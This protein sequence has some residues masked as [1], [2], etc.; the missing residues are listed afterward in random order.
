MQKKREMTDLC[1]TYFMTIPFG[2]NIII[3]LLSFLLGNNKLYRLDLGYFQLS[4]EISQKQYLS[5]Y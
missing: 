3:I 4:G 2:S 1:L 5:F